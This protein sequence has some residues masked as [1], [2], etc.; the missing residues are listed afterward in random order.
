M[1]R[2]AGRGRVDSKRSVVMKMDARAKAI[3]D[4][5]RATLHRVRDVEVEYRNHEDGDHLTAWSRGMPKKPPPPTIEQ[6]RQEIADALAKQPRAL[7]APDVRQMID[8]TFLDPVRIDSHGKLIS[9][10][11]KRWRA[12]IARLELSIDALVRAETKRIEAA[13]RGDVIDLP[14]RNRRA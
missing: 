12:E 8:D 11:R 5:A 10:E 13:E 2:S 3:F 1:G 7:T 4:E 14:A 9:D 6:V